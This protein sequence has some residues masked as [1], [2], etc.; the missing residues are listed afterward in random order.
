MVKYFRTGCTLRVCCRAVKGK[1]SR[2]DPLPGPTKDDRI[3]PGQSVSDR[4]YLHQK[5]LSCV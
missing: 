3:V 4:E 1:I 2:T 5:E